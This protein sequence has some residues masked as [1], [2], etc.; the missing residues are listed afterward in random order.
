MTEND[1][2][3]KDAET[4]EELA[5]EKTT[6]SAADTEGAEES[7]EDAVRVLK[8]E[9]EAASRESEASQERFVRLYAEFDN[10]KK[11]SARELQDFR[12]FANE[13]L[14]RELLP[15]IDNLE[16]AIQSSDGSEAAANCIVEGVD[17]TRKGILEVFEKYHVTPVESLGT[18]FDPSFHE[19]VGQEE[20]EEHP[21]N[22]VVREFQKG[23]LL[24]D[25]LIRPAMVIVSKARVP[26][27]ETPEATAAPEEENDQ[28]NNE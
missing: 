3:E 13:S 22:I 4:A 8:E 28:E 7:G 26:E 19:A 10:Y 15:V 9:L 5:E 18:P 23:Y 25:R 11:R 27:Q 1:K 14:I 17:M 12:K 20:S 6:A 21:D 24:H 16:R 2:L